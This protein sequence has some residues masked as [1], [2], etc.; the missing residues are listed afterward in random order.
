MSAEKHPGVFLGLAWAAVLAGTAAAADWPAFNHDPQR[1]GITPE[2]LSFPLALVWTYEPGLRPH[3]AWPEPG[4]E[5]HRMD[6][7][8]AFQPVI[9]DGLVFFGSSADDAVRAVRAE[10]G[11]L[12]W[13]F[14]APGPVRFAPA[15]AGGKVYLASDDGCAYC[16]EAKTGSLVRRFPA[17]PDWPSKDGRWPPI[18]TS[19]ARRAGSTPRCARRLAG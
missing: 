7:D 9:A 18:W 10:S 4:K 5:L 2:P 3:P 1:S 15:V 16:L 14:A 13:R 19:S 6:F 12:A 8:Y 11:E 17:A